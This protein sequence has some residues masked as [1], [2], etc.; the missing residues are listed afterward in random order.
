M[1]RDIE[2]HICHCRCRCIRRKTPT[3]IKAPLVNINTSQPLE[4]V[5]ID[6]ITLERSKGGYEYV[7]VMTDHFSRFAMAIPT[8]DITAKTTAEVFYQNF[9]VYL[10]IQQKI[11]SDQG[12]NFE[13]KIIKELCSLFSIQK[14]RTTPYHLMGN[15]QCERF[16]RTLISMFETL[17]PDEKQDW[18]SFIKPI[19]Q[20]YNCTKQASTSF[21]PYYLMFGR[22]PNLPI[23]II[24]DDNT[25]VDNTSKSKYIES[26][27]DIFMFSYNLA[28]KN[29]QVAQ[30]RQQRNYDVKIKS[31]VLKPDDLVLVKIV[32]FDGRYKVAVKWEMIPMLLL[33][34]KMMTFLYTELKNRLVKAKSEFYIKNY[35]FPSVHLQILMI[36]QNQFLEKENHSS[37][38]EKFPIMDQ[39]TADLV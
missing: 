13:S 10:G 17:N 14:S 21:S 25:Q 7:L 5:C 28:L 38:V 31:S 36:N 19:V 8:K 9:I 26:L 2:N 6:F 22:E 37:K 27:K 11:H 30:A 33:I 15:G 18:K 32:V 24:L 29:I 23:D 4:L 12:A 1:N 39:L 34:T 20:A 35:Y 16:N 3:N